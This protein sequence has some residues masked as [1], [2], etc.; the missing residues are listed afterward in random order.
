[1]AVYE[2]IKFDIYDPNAPVIITSL[3]SVCIENVWYTIGD[4]KLLHS[5]IWKNIS[6]V[7]RIDDTGQWHLLE[8]L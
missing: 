1:M 7:Y 3:K 2:A 8:S 6:Q 4:T 5:S